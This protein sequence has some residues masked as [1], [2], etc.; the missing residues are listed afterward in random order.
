MDIESKRLRR[1]PDEVI[2]Q[3]KHANA[4]SRGELRGIKRE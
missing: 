3:R 1:E 4:R 2:A